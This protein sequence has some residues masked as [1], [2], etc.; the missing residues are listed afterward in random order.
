MSFRQSSGG[1]ASTSQC[2]VATT[3]ARRR[4]CSCVAPT[5]GPARATVR[6]AAWHRHAGSRESLLTIA[7]VIGPEAMPRGL[8]RL[9]Q[10]LNQ[11]KVLARTYHFTS[12]VNISWCFV[13]LVV[14][15]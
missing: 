14:V 9:F 11:M 4:L 7:N 5:R 13:D 12:M 15:L 1:R 8:L 3:E 6:V 2:L 10:G